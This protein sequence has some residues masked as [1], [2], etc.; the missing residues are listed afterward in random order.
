MISSLLLGSACLPNSSRV[1]RGSGFNPVAP[2]FMPFGRYADVGSQRI[3][4]SH[5]GLPLH[6]WFVSPLRLL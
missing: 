4:S 6:G 2:T 3:E 5:P 1:K